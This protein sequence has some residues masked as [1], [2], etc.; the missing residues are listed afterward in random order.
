MFD[1]HTA[2]QV[3]GRLAT[4][5]KA[6]FLMLSTGGQERQH[7]LG[8]SM[9]IPIP[10]PPEDVRLSTRERRRWAAMATEAAVQGGAGRQLFTVRHFDGGPMNR[11][12]P[13]AVVHVGSGQGQAWVRESP[14]ELQVCCSQ[15]VS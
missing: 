2:W 4:W 1:D 9:S 3:K 8:V 12:S 11:D 10:S 15:E 14:G 6:T 7:M 5:T 13:L